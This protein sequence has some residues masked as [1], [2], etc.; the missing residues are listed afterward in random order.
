MS[1]ITIRPGVIT[2]SGVAMPEWLSRNDLENG[3]WQVNQGQAVRGEAWTDRKSRIM[4]VPFGDDPMARTI[5]AH[6]MMH[7]KISPATLEFISKLSVSMESVRA[8][9]E[10]RVN[11]L[12]GV[13]G[14]DTDPMRD[15]SESNSGKRLAEIGDW[16]NFV[17]FIAA[18]A[19]TKGCKDVLRGA[20]SVNPEFADA[21]KRVEKAI[22]Q[23]WKD[24][25]KK[26]GRLTDPTSAKK[27]AKLVGSTK[28]VWL[29]P[30]TGTFLDNGDTPE[31]EIVQRM[32]NRGDSSS[33][34]LAPKG[35]GFTMQVATLLEA[36]LKRDDSVDDG[37]SGDEPSDMPS[38]EELDAALTTGKTWAP[39]IIDKNLPL[40]RNVAG[41]LGRKRIATNIG[42]NPRR[43]ERIL[44]D[45]ERRI[46]D[47]TIKGSGGIVLIDMSGSMHISERELND[48][49]EAAPGCVV[50]GYSHQSNSSGVPNTWILA[51]RGKVCAR[52]PHGN[53]GNGVDGPALQFALKLRKKGE[54][55]IWVCDGYVT[56]SDDNMA[57]KSLQKWCA[58]L[59]RKHNIHMTESVESGIKALRKTASGQRLQTNLVGPLALTENR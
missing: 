19:G 9:E 25:V 58:D 23:K 59:V 15:G 35:F 42:I 52:I 10:F 40:T 8:A 11:T 46:F 53:G 48:L 41:R 31:S 50:I 32:V 1:N 18:T 38:S 57:P 4:Q 6:E 34:V 39:L 37:V 17:L 28:P 44:T 22:I 2:P 56:V 24:E 14:F 43:I 12:V 54:P 33:P 27:A 47:R 13:A 30:V 3:A 16:N 49:V 7:A 29:H 5:R 55:F 45:P 20:R 51:N 26:Y 21:G 36:L